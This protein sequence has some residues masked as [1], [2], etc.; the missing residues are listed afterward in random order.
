MRRNVLLLACS[1]AIVLLGVY[2]FRV[3][4]SD[5]EPESGQLMVEVT[6]PSLDATTKLGERLFNENC[7]SCHG[8]NAAGQEG[9][10]PPLVH[11]IY[12]PNHHAD[13]SFLIAVKQG[14]RAHHWP[15]GNMPPVEGLTDEDVTKIVAY[16][17]L[18][19]KANGVY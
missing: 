1:L 4:G 6:V 16:V 9:I 3:G 2:V 13:G 14:V 11:K 5:T 15:F 8:E 18:L 17:R 12:E 19:Q 10:A 7:A